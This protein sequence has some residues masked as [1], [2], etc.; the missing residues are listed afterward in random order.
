MIFGP[1]I[2][3]ERCRFGASGYAEVK[4]DLASCARYVLPFHRYPM[5]LVFMFYVNWIRLPR[6][7]V[8]LYVEL[9]WS[10]TNA[11]FTRVRIST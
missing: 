1:V 11:S 6:D 5:S 4:N 9:D 3:V 2:L 8:L 7:L 10:K